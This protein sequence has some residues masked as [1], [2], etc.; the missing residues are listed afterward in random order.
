MSHMDSWRNFLCIFMDTPAP[1]VQLRFDYRM[2][3]VINVSKVPD[4]T[5]MRTVMPKKSLDCFH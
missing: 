2:S 4:R 3:S 1:G 5:Y